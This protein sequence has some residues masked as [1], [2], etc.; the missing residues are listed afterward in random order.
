[1]IAP[2]Y[3]LLYFCCPPQISTPLL[4]TS[5]QRSKAALSRRRTRSRPS[6]SLRLGSIKAA[7]VEL[8]YSDGNGYCIILINT[9]SYMKAG[10]NCKFGFSI[11][12]DRSFFFFSQMVRKTSQTQKKNH[13]NQIQFL[14]LQHL[15]PKFLCFQV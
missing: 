10:T 3:L 13:L 14:L 15:L 2:L 4:D 12:F 6:R 9:S 8:S 5:T 11:E 7:R 1:M